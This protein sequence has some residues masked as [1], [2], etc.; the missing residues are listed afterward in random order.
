M[1]KILFSALATLA[2]APCIGKQKPN[3]VIF[4]ADDL[5]WGDLSL[6]NTDPAY[7]R[8]TPNIDNMFRSGIAMSNYVTHCVCSP[9]RAGLLTG[10]HYAKVNS[11]PLTGGTLPLEIPNI[12]RDFKSADYKT[13]AF[14]KWHNGMPPFPAQDNAKI[15]DFNKL[16][17]WNELHHV[18]TA[19]LNNG[20]FDNTKGYEWGAGVNAYGF[21]RWVG[22]YNGGGDLFDRFINWHH[23]IDWWHDRNY[24]PNE[25]GYTTDLITKH[26]TDFIAEN[27][28]SSFFCY[29]PFHAVHA[30]IQVKLSDLKELCSFFPGEWVRQVVGVGNLCPS[31]IHTVYIALQSKVPGY[32]HF[33]LDNIVIRRRDGSVHPVI[34]KSDENSA[35]ASIRYGKSNYSTISK[36]ISSPEFSLRQLT[37]STIKI[38]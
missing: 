33:Y 8:Y 5:G 26:A 13:G 2:M 15:E 21:D 30:P 16:K 9:S 32:Y 17:R 25:K 37:V 11:G 12:A 22:Y 4:F 29:I 31:S 19:D 1:K 6:N 14:G 38:N 23:D 34:W 20:I 24:V 3:V 27:S 10:K 28:K 35:N 36:A 18:Y 7:Y